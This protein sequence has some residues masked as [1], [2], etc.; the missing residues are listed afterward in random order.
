MHFYGNESF[1]L[2]LEGARIYDLDT[3]PVRIRNWWE[4]ENTKLYYSFFQEHGKLFEKG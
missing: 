3:V 4:L 1:L 2:A